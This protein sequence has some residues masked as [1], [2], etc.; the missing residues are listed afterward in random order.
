MVGGKVKKL[1]L[2]LVL[3]VIPRIVFAECTY[4]EKYELNALSSYI[5]YNYE[6]NE[7]SGLFTIT[8]MNVNDKLEIR[9]K[10]Y[11]YYPEN[12][13]IVIENIEPGTR[14]SL[15]VYSTVYNE[16][17]NEYL[18]VIYVS[19]PYFNR[20]YG[21]VLCKGYENLDICNSRFLD[22]KISNETFLLILKNYEYTLS[23]KQDDGNETVD[24]KWYEFVM[25]FF[26][27]YFFKILVSVISFVI[28][29]SIFNVIFRKVK[30]KL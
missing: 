26:Q 4:S 25:N 14:L 6:Y 1:L 13:K 20:Y 30:H 17:Y 23:D 27:E 8:L 9:N 21:S 10:N 22:Y 3:L 2:F 15:D 28:S 11:T 29:I 16:C 5:D 7:A 24:E 19:V 12:N 18:R